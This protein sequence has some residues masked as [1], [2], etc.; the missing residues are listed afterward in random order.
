MKNIK[1]YEN[2]TISIN[3]VVQNIRTGRFLRQCKNTKAYSMVTLSQNGVSK[4]LTIHK[5]VYIT[6]ISDVNKGFEINHIDGNKNNNNLSNLELVTKKE[7]MVKAVLNGQIKSG[8]ECNLSVQVR[9]INPLT[10]EVI[11]EYGSIAIATKQTKIA[12]SAISCVINKKSR[13]TAG[14]FIWEKINKDE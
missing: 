14:G 11:S 3:G 4:T 13:L 7:N 12:G 1:G 5:L 10:K 2:Y 9:Q 6:Y 8:E